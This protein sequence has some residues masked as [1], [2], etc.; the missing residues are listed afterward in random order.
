MIA[1]VSKSFHFPNHLSWHDFTSAC[2][3]LISARSIASLIYIP[4]HWAHE[5]PISV[6]KH[7]PIWQFDFFFFLDKTSQILQIS[8]LKCGNTWGHYFVFSIRF[9][10]ENNHKDKIRNRVDATI[11]KLKKVNLSE[12]NKIQTESL[13]HYWTD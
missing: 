13:S 8:F 10:W 6:E 1:I 11:T 2:C 7:C 12:N 3:I 9:M 5:P 4:K